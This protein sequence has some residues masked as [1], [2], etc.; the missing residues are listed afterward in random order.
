M[1]RAVILVMDSFGVGASADA[2]RFG[3]AGADTFG[4]IAAACAAGRADRDGLRAGPLRLPHL[5]RLG[6]G[7]AATGSSGAMPAGLAYDGPF[8]GAFGHAAEASTGKDTPSGHWEIA[9][10]PVSFDWGLFPRTRP[11]FPP[12]LVAALIEGCG[13]TGILGDCH[14]SGTEIVRELGE[15]HIRTGKPICYTSADSVFQIA[16]HE[17]H[18]G[19]QRLYAVSAEAKRLLAPW[20][21][22]RVIARPFLGESSANFTRTANRKDLTTPPHGETLLDLLVAA[23]GRVVSVGKIADIF[24][25]RGI[26]EKIAAKDNMALF[27]ATLDALSGAADGTLIFANFVDFDTHFGHRR[28]VAGYAAALEAFDARLP[29]LAARLCT[30]DLALITA[31]HGCDPTWPGSD[32]TREHVPMLWF[33]P[34]VRLQDLGRRA[35]FADMGQTLARHFCLPPLAYGIACSLS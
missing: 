5:L 9:G 28:D 15:A 16:A 14:A 30:S 32:H 12:E 19:L 35:S 7:K 33:G 25:G 1:S 10:L 26:S 17:T 23:G 3:D 2:A 27:D 22:A 11:C 6:L 4:H 18:F 21:I 34:D 20:N 29:E 24:A 8:E 31:D 13:L